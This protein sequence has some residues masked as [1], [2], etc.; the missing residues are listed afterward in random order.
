MNKALTAK[1]IETLM[2]C[3]EKEI[4]KEEP[5]DASTT[6]S[7]RGLIKRGMMNTKSHFTKAGKKIIA[8]YVTDL[9]RS[10]LNRL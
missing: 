6:K 2:D 3:H 10:Y 9:G 1:M 7:M 8:L 4:M 5:C